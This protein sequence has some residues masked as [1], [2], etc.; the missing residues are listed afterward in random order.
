MKR[1]QLEKVCYEW[2]SILKFYR[3]QNHD[4]TPNQETLPQSI[5][6]SGGTCF[7]LSFCLFYCSRFVLVGWFLLVQ[8]PLEAKQSSCAQL[9]SQCLQS[10]LSSIITLSMRVSEFSLRA[11]SLTQYFNHSTC[12]CHAMGKHL[13][14][15]TFF[16]TEFSLF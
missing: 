7:E 12:T 10:L 6:Q 14:K 5:T 3:N 2:K 16:S 8:I 9:I 13:T 15:E 11:S 4:F 1:F